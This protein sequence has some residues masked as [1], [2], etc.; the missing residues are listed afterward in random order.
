MGRSW[1][2]FEVH[3]RN[4]EAK[5]NPSEIGS[6]LLETGRKNILVIK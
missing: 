5:G 2:S 6:I 3:G 1:K 4:M